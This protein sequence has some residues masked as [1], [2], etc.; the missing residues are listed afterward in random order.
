MSRPAKDR[1]DVRVFN[2]IGVVAQLT[3]TVMERSLPDGLSYASFSLLGHFAMRGH[4]ESPAQLAETFQVTKGAITNTLQRLQTQGLI[5]MR[6][7]KDDGRKKWVRITH[8]G[9]SVYEAALVGMRPVMSSLRQRFD[10]ADFEA[11]LPFLTA[12]RGWLDESR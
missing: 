11:V 7:D 4:E 10:E 3:R 12:L 2:E 9:L 5:A 6:A 1:P 8:K